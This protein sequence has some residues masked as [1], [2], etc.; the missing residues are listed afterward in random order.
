MPGSIGGIETA[1]TVL[2]NNFSHNSRP[3]YTAE[4]LQSEKDKSR[5][6]M[7]RKDV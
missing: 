6:P 7:K 3:H 2:Q 5:S 1:A 4:S